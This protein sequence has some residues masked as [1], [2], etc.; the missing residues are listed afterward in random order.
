MKY[1]LILSV[2]CTF[3]VSCSSPTPPLSHLQRRSIES[4]ELKGDYTDAFKATIAVLQDNGYV[5]NNA[6]IDSGVIQGE[7]GGKLDA[8]KVYSINYEVTAT[9]EQ[10]GEG[11]VKERITFVRKRKRLGQ[12]DSL[13]IDKPEFLQ[14]IY[15]EIQ[16][17]I[18]IRQNL[19]R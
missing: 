19:N 3:A 5:I 15:D 4:K 13:L 10:Y 2:L 16:K 14:K 6:D 18:F 8:W 7:T 1:P 12:E 17:E 9:L 11:I